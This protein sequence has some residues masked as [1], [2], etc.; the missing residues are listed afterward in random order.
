[1]AVLELNS[2]LLAT[3]TGL[4]ASITNDYQL[5]VDMLEPW[6]C[7]VAI[8]PQSSEWLIVAG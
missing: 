7:R 3:D 6:L 8:V 2:P 5:R 1:M 4:N